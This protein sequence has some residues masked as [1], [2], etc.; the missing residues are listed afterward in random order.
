MGI[1]NNISKL[2]GKSIQR[3][4]ATYDVVLG[5]YAKRVNY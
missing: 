3:L 5:D 4:D 1:F 2:L